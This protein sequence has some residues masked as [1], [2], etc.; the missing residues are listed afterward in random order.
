MLSQFLDEIIAVLFLKLFTSMHHCSSPTGMVALLL[1]HLEG[2]KK[3][4]LK[5]NTFAYK[6]SGGANAIWN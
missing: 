2:E 4:T 1:F 5:I 3:I 6:P